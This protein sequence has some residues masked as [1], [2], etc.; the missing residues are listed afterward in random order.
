MKIGIC[1]IC[2]KFFN[3]ILL[4]I[5]STLASQGQG[6][7]TAFAVHKL[8]VQ[9]RHGGEST[10]A[11]GADLVTSAATLNGAVAGA[12]VGAVPALLGLRQ[13]ERYSAYREQVILSRYANGWPIPADVRQKL[14][15][16]H[17]HRTKQDIAAAH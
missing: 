8:F 6:R 2:R 4:F 16:K 1:R 13:A 11:S 15:R 10:A 12:M 3:L 9:K 7:D 5:F 14:R 17:F